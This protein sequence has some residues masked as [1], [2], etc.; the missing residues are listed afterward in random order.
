MIKIANQVID[1]SDDID[2]S[3][4]KKIA[5]KRPNTSV[6]DSEK[7]ASLNDHEFALVVMTKRA[8]KLPK[9]P[10]NDFDSAWLS[11]EY[12]SHTYNNLPAEAQKIAASNIKCACECYK[13]KPTKAVEHF[14]KE[15]CDNV[16]HEKDNMFDSQAL[17]WDDPLS[18]F[19]QVS[20]ITS[21]ETYETYD[22]NNK[23]AVNTGAEY[24]SK[25]AEKMPVAYRHKYASAL[26]K[27][28]TELGFELEG[29]VAAYAGNAYSNDLDAHIRARKLLIKEAKTNAVLEKVAAKNND[30]TPAEFA[31]LLHDFD[32]YARLERY[33]GSALKDPY[34]STFAVLSN[35]KLASK[36]S[37][38]FVKTLADKHMAK[39]KEYFGKHVAEEFKK[40]PEAVYESLPK[41]AKEMMENIANGN[42]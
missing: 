27:R 34:L 17:T 21:N 4:L 6:M 26:Q 2:C 37:P 10:I 25:F 8:Q 42:G 23:E 36:S 33:Y 19:A 30:C 31:Q 14:A 3:I 38:D 18:K 20:K 7:R 22:F 39:I 28:A 12:F 5:S 24:F 9:F 40:H 13:I 16:F 35:T 29:K 15:A 11:N 41:D 1:V 32:K